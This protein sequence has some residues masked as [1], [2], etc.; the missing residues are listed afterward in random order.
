MTYPLLSLI[1][2]SR[3]V[4]TDMIGVNSAMMP[5]GIL[6]FAPVIPVVTRRYGARIVAVI[7]ALLTAV[8]ILSYKVFDNLAAWFLLRLLQGMSISTLFVLSEAWIVGF[9]SSE[10]RGRIVAIYGSILSLS[11][12]AGPALV[13]WIGIEGWTPF[14]L[15]TVIILL[16]IVPLALVREEGTAQPTENACL[17]HHR[18]CAQ[19]THA[20]GRRRCIRDFRRRHIVATPRLWYSD[21]PRR[22]D[23]GYRTDCAHRWQRGAAVSDRLAR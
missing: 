7:A 23:S 20:G 8:L 18:V 4:S 2:E 1:L 22:D 14:V 21:R 3:G 16:G 13:G 5:I 6:L 11:F 19:G 17:W 15:G 10:H 12:G 9:A